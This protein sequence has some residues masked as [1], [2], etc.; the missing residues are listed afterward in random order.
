MIVCWYLR[1]WSVSILLLIPRWERNYMALDDACMTYHVSHVALRHEI[2]C[3][4]TSNQ[5]ARRSSWM[6][7]DLI[8]L[9][10]LNVIFLRVLLFPPYAFPSA[11]YFFFPKLPSGISGLYNPERSSAQNWNRTETDFH[12]IVV[13]IIF[14]SINHYICLYK[15]QLT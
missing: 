12:V 1:W 9:L 6:V 13:F 2:L 8:I 11:P 3:S 5:D 4:A 10:G 7:L 15:R 14:F